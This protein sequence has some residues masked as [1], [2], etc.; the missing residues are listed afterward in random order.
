[1]K[2]RQKLA[3]VLAATMM[4]T[5]VPV[6]TMA[7][8]E[9]YVTKTVKVAKDAKTGFETTAGA[10]GQKETLDPTVPDNA[11]RINVTYKS[12]SNTAGDAFLVKAT[13]GEFADIQENNKDYGD[14]TI[15]RQSETELLVTVDANKNIQLPMYAVAKGGELS[16]EIV[17][18]NSEV[19]GGKYV[20][21][22]TD[23]TNKKGITT[24]ADAVSLYENGTLG[25]VTVTE[26]YPGSFKS[27]TDNS[28]RVIKVTLENDDFSYN[29]QNGDVIA[30]MGR[31]FG[32]YELKFGT[33]VTVDAKDDQTL[34][35]AIPAAQANSTN[36]SG[37]VVIDG[38]K[39]NSRK[40]DL[41]D[42]NVT[43]GGD[44]VEEKTYTLGK[45]VEFGVELEM[46]DE[47]A[48]DI[49]AG[50]QDKVTFNFNETIADS[51]AASREVEF[52]LD[53][54]HF[55]HGIK[56]V[57]TNGTIVL[58]DKT[59][60]I[61][62]T[63]TLAKFKSEVAG[64]IKLDKNEI[65]KDAITSLIY[66]GKEV[67]G[68]TFLPKGLADSSKV[69]KYTFED[70]KVEVNINNTG[71]VK[72]TAEGTRSFGETL[73]TEAV[74][75]VTPVEVKA[76]PITVKVGLKEQ[77]GGKVTIKETDKGMLKKG[78]SL[79]IDLE[80]E[81]GM[82]FSGKPTVKV[83]GGDLKLGTDFEIEEKDGKLEISI[84]RASKE[85]STIEISDFKVKLDRTVPEGTY[86]VNIGGK[87]LTECDTLEVKDFVV[88]G[89]PN[90]E[91]ANGLRKGTATFVIGSDKYVVNGEGKSM[92]AK[93]Y[94]SAKGRTMIPVRYLS[95]AFGVEGK[96]IM[97]SNGTV[98][99]LAGN[100]TIQLTNGSDIALV[101]GAQLKMDEKVTIKDNR[102]YVPVSQV[103]VIL[104]VEA[105]WDQ[106]AQTA[107][108]T[109]K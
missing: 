40:P 69:E 52:K 30:K 34:N 89:T 56:E 60:E 27:E 57:T 13:N 81:E 64:K 3:A 63:E 25:K 74:N 88:V 23:D 55:M 6:V 35:I 97:F 50:R 104:G 10:A 43:I 76:E 80:D 66:D 101:N 24:A 17:S 106:Q 105:K 108:F 42:L 90:P 103:G 85:A 32:A 95:D 49:K 9:N 87:A 51:L 18:E 62:K 67:V 102:T 84:K 21:A 59:S 48:V 37:D 98:V 72:L 4:V 93:A 100:K 99:I 109:N 1:M 26:T 7:A 33:D 41:G 38:L 2:L 77:V 73:E 31:G 11:P 96:N 86:A 20:V 79:V 58:A 91:D 94:V 29:Y 28:K 83:T 15:K 70:F 82:K 44:L 53:N 46:K 8:S 78:E 71:K 36:I 107:T 65:S 45:V 5:A 22:V 75:I 16:V 54:G 19:T 12:G 47:K 68:F 14:F 92:D 61:N 39:V